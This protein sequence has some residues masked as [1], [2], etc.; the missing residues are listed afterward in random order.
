VHREL[1]RDAPT[2]LSTFVV[3]AYDPDDDDL[4]RVDVPFWFVRLKTSGPINLGTLLSA[5][6]SD[7]D[8]LDLSITVWCEDRP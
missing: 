3:L 6:S 2:D 5:L 7:W 1:E 8:N 4:L